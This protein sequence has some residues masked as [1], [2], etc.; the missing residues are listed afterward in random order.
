M[1]DNTRE[2]SIPPHQKEI[3]LQR[4]IEKL[5]EDN[6]RLRQIIEDQKLQINTLRQEVAY[7]DLTGL[8]KRKFFNRR[9]DEEFSKLGDNQERRTDDTLKHISIVFL[10]I[11]H[12][13]NINDT[14]G[15]AKGDAVLKKVGNTLSSNVRESDLV[16]RWGGEEMV[17]ALLGADESE[18]AKI[19]ETLRSVIEKEVGVTTSIGIASYNEGIS[20]DELI[21]RADQTMYK[22][23]HKPGGRNCVELYSNL[24]PEDLNKYQPSKK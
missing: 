6:A 3:D 16:C 21:D 7:D 12:F 14:K 10:D 17:I 23:K 20:P 8:Y 24:T 19:A 11:D 5:S 4:K 22:A 13:K 18:S 2:Q 15:H 9:L 1:I